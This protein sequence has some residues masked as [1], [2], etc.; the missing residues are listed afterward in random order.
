M[1]GGLK[2]TPGDA[3]PVLAYDGDCGFCQATIDLIRRTAGPRIN[4]VP[5]QALPEQ[6]TAPHRARLDKE[7]LLLH[8]GAVSAGGADALARLVGSS[9]TRRYQIAA[10]AATLPGVRAC[11]RRLYTLMAQ[12]R[13]RMPGATAS[14]A[15]RHP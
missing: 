2:N 6:L 12:N 15:R 7:V 1:S 4:A 13:R 9:P 14:C 10:A 8:N 3:G 5:W 11:A